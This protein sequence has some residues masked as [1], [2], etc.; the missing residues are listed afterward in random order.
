MPSPLP[1]QTP[2][3]PANTPENAAFL[4]A[5]RAFQLKIYD[6][7]EMGL[8]AFLKNYPN[9]SR[10]PEAILLDAQAKIKQSKLEPAIRLL[11]TNLPNAGL[12][13]D[14][15]R[16]WL[17][18][19]YMQSSNY[20][21]AAET[22][23]TLI[24][25]HPE[26]VRLLEASYGEAL[27]RFKLKEWSRV[28]ELLQNPQGVFQIAAHQ[29]A[30]DELVARGALLIVEALSAKGDYEAAEKSLLA[31]EEKD[32]FAE[33]KWWRNYHLCRVRMARH[34]FQAALDNTTNLLASVAAA[35]KRKFQ[36]ESIFLQGEILELM[37]RPDD[38]IA[39]YT[40]N[41]AETLPAEDRRRALVRIIDLSLSHQK[42]GDA[43]AKIERFLKQYPDD[44]ASDAILLSLGE[45]HLRQYAS[46]VETNATNTLVVATNTLQ[47]ALGE[48][49]LMVKN[50]PKSSLLGK[51]QLDRGWC[52]WLQEKIAESVAAF[53]SASD[54]LSFA[55]DLAVARFKLGDALFR[56]GDLTNALASYSSVVKDFSD[57]AA[58]KNR[59]LDQVLYQMLRV[60][61]DLNDADSAA[62]ALKT[63]I[64]QYPASSLNDR[65]MLLVG[66]KLSRVGRESE[67]RSILSS[68]VGKFPDNDLVPQVE[69]TLA[70][71][72]V[73]E[74]QWD[75]AIDKYES[76]LARYTNSSLRGE[77]ESDRAWANYK[78]GNETNALSLYTNFVAQFPD[79]ALAPLAQNWVADYYFRHGDYRT[80]EK[81]YQ[82]LF[83]HTNWPVSALTY[84]GRMMAGRS[85]FARQVYKDADHYFSD[86]TT[87]LPND[88]TDMLAEAYYRLGDSI[89]EGSRLETTK[90]YD[91]RFGNA[92]IAFGNLNK[93]YPTNRW[94]ILA[95]GR[96]G[97]CHFQL[98]AQDPERY[99]SAAKAYQQLID[100][101][102]VDTA[103]RNQAEF[104][105]GMVLEKKAQLKS[106]E[107]G[108]LL[109]KQ[110]SEHYYK[111]LFSENPDPFWLKEA[112]LAAARLAEDQKEWETAINIY[113]RLAS[114]LPPL[115]PAMERKSDKAREQMHVEKG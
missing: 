5:A 111:I 30:N 85:A 50:F 102:G 94:G 46:G 98:A 8:D 11:T 104:G 54:Q 15:Y 70:R 34:H 29:R 74:N 36:T 33:A 53:K 101:P 17:G 22:F 88:A 47:Q 43:A 105:I 79:H 27:A 78:A 56:Q 77:A 35:G 90:P 80:A 25:S 52:F 61:L 48:L 96:I 67:A 87:L 107:E 83:Q 42:L 73:Q 108:L 57:V 14:Q 65:S 92:L 114:L 109:L 58:V 95:L 7:A 21:S 37:D 66:Q 41:E 60:S 112:G 55:E 69:L 99:D 39:V 71:T 44:K 91:S 16:Y 9:S 38:A 20:N 89:A 110:A 68:F 86:L 82:E 81:N 3:A 84:Q 76:W 106:K 12:L 103:A 24:K 51:A 59:F 10:L 23:A 1:A 45:L 4:A 26:S 100:S 72:Y 75:A 113:D 49:D 18:E 19:S 62:S 28:V 97:D 13:S 115:K 31:L 63:L 6:N 64:D 93:Q 40:L 2:Q 32:L